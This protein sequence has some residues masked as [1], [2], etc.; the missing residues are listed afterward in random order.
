MVDMDNIVTIFAVIGASALAF[1]LGKGCIRKK[2]GGTR[3]P[4]KNRAASVAIE[5]IQ[6]TFKEEV[7]GVWK[8]VEGKDPA[9]DLADRGNARDRK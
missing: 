1:F 9:G 2:K 3:S 4:P 6:Q 7:D 8:D 5:T